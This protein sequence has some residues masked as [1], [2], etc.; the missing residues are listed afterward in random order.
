MRALVPEAP[1][2]EFTIAQKGHHARWLPGCVQRR[3]DKGSGRG[4][5]RH[6]LR[7]LIDRSGSATAGQSETFDISSGSLAREGLTMFDGGSL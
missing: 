5:S 3:G 6:G 2:I 1:N 7:K 4:V